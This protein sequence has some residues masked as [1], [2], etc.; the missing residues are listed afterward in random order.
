MAN[1]KDI[2]GQRFGKVV[3]IEPFKQDKK[4]R[5]Y[6]RCYCDCGSEFITLSAS[7]ISGKTTTCGCVRRVNTPVKANTKTEKVFRTTFQQYIER[8]YRE[9][10]ECG[11]T[12]T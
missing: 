11:Q 4:G 5:F 6:W 12:E 9:V 2:T 8:K 1:R 3:A 10:S 7:L